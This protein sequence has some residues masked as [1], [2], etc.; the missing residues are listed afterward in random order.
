MKTNKGFREYTEEEI[1]ELKEMTDLPSEVALVA[2]M[3]KSEEAFLSLERYMSPSYDFF[4]NTMKKL[5]EYFSLCYKTYASKID[6]Q[7]FTQFMLGTE[8]REMFYEEIGG[9]EVIDEMMKTT[10]ATSFDKYFARIKKYALLREYYRKGFPSKKIMQM[11]N[12]EELMPDQILTIMQTNLDKIYTDIGG[13][14]EA[15]LLGSDAVTR[16]KELRKTPDIGVAVADWKIMTG[17]IRGLRKKKVTFVGMVSNDGKSRMSTYMAVHNAILTKTPTLVIMNETDDKDAFLCAMTTILN[18]PSFEY[19]SNIK[20]EAMATGSYESEEQF[21]DVLEIAE[22]FERNT[23]IYFIET[24]KYADKDLERE[25][26]KYVIGKGVELVVYDTM[27]ST[28]DN[29]AT[30]K[31]TATFLKDLATDLNIH[32]WATFQCTDDV[33][34]IAPHEMSNMNIASAKQI[35]HLCDTMFML[36]KVEDK[37]RHRYVFHANDL[38]RYGL[39][40]GKGEFSL[41]DDLT[42]YYSRCIKNR[43]GKKEDTIL[44]V[45]LDYNKWEE[46]GFAGLKQSAKKGE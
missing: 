41:K 18:A 24:T 10:D 2:S 13:G 11:K 42:Y 26:K 30:L 5:Y 17:M 32:I 40:W 23:N 34:E 43:A 25:I 3:F 14:K 33:V 35:R 22:W 44:E 19:N 12:F 20:E 16:L 29:W 37:F 45:D 46:V 7:T 21:E 38:T 39:A 31:A 36:R 9:W 15:I 1:E 4:D 6:S 27:K 8:E 28:D